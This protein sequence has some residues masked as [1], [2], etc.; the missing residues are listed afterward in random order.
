MHDR[1][2]FDGIIKSKTTFGD[3]AKGKVLSKVWKVI[4]TYIQWVYSLIDSILQT[5]PKSK[6]FMR[7]LKEIWFPISFETQFFALC[8]DVWCKNMYFVF[9]TFKLHLII[10]WS[11]ILMFC[12]IIMQSMDLIDNLMPHSVLTTL[13]FYN[14]W[15]GY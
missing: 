1:I 3:K 7:N 11:L 8:V 4:F 5:L 2:T 14:I 13:S 6:F 10:I 9:V 15:N 12:R